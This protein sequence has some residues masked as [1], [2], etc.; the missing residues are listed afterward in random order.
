M[1]PPCSLASGQTIVE[2]MAIMATSFTRTC[3]DCLFIFPDPTV[4]HCQPMPPLQATGHSQGS[5]A[6]SWVLLHTRSCLCPPRVCLSPI[7]WKFCNQILLA[8]KSNSPG[9]LNP[10]ADP[11]V[12]KSVVGPR[13]LTSVGEPLWYNCCCS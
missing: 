13:T 4:G 10:F 2:I 7:L 1:A 6:Q 11:Q 12:G 8:F 5:L 3:Q 9:V